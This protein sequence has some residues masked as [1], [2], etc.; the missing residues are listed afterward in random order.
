MPWLQE[1]AV[2]LSVSPVGKQCFYRGF[3]R[4]V[5]TELEKCGVVVAVSAC[6]C[7]PRRYI[8]PIPMAMTSARGGASLGIPPWAGRAPRGPYSRRRLE[9]TSPSICGRRGLI[10]KPN[11]W[12]LAHMEGRHWTATDYSLPDSMVGVVSSSE[13]QMRAAQQSTANHKHQ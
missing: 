11:G 3:Q 6:T 8:K 12:R 2:T 10:R 9:A 4:P 7:N 1:V 5:G 13:W